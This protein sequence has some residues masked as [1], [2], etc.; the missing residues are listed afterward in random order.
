MI[1]IPSL[2]VPVLNTIYRVPQRGGG[3]AIHQTNKSLLLTL[4]AADAQWLFGRESFHA[5][6]ET[7]SAAAVMRHAAGKMRLSLI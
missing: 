1:G 7:Q 2:P 5:F 3:G 4:L 6:N